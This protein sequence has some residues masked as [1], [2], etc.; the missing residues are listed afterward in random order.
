M[1]GDGGAGA[2]VTRVLAVGGEALVRA[3]ADPGPRTFA[4]AE[5]VRCALRAGPVGAG[6]GR[7]RPGAG[8]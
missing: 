4:D 2:W 8:R 1:R 3:G 5:V 6:P 7:C